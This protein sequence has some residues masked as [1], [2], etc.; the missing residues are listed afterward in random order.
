MM[1][2][3]LTMLMLWLL[4]VSSFVSATEVF[5]C[6][7]ADGVRLF[8]ETPLEQCSSDTELVLLDDV[9]P[10][11]VD[12]RY[13]VINQ[14]KRF[15]QR[16]DKE[17]RAK[18]EKRLLEAKLR[19]LK[20]QELASQQVQTPASPAPVQQ[21]PFFFPSR[22]G[23]FPRLGDGQRQRQRQRNRQ[24]APT[25]DPRRQSGNGIPSR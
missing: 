20:R 9:T 25:V 14:L 6:M 8:S 7:D 19:E 5:T 13:S 23:L 17:Q 3:T 4:S 12:D 2:L 18:L 10:K 22:S 11:P 15:E 16:R 24:T 21:Q 1:R